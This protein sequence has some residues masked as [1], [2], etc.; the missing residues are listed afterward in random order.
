MGKEIEAARRSNVMNESIIC[1]PTSAETLAVTNVVCR[2]LCNFLI[3]QKNPEI[4]NE[5]GRQQP[6][7]S[8]LTLPATVQEVGKLLNAEKCEKGR[9]LYFD[10]TDTRNHRS[11]LIHNYDAQFWVHYF[12]GGIGLVSVTCFSQL[13]SAE[14][15][16]LPFKSRVIDA[17]YE[18][19]WF[20]HK[21]PPKFFQSG[22][23]KIYLNRLAKYFIG[24]VNLSLISPY[25][26]LLEAKKINEPYQFVRGSLEKLKEI[27][28]TA[29]LVNQGIQRTK[30]S[31]EYQRQNTSVV[32]TCGTIRDCSV[33]EHCSEWF[34]NAV[35]K[36]ALE[37]NTPY[38]VLNE[39][40]YRR[41]ESIFSDWIRS[42]KYRIY[43]DFRTKVREATPREKI[44]ARFQLVNW[45]KE[46]GSEGERIIKYYKL[47]NES[48]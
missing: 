14:G 25:T 7:V 16:V 34:I 33:I 32:V 10:C 35:G 1:R 36:L 43:L 6:L 40:Y 37:E 5:R 31:T 42:N 26:I 2:E 13:A 39:S 12:R 8:M 41:T 27:L 22:K 48:N 19:Q 44:A 30:N 23:S 21:L 3:Y 15:S 29:F 9:K 20:T 18:Y 45:L 17:S 47:A 38:T 11:I 28:K 4:L 24:K 46:Q